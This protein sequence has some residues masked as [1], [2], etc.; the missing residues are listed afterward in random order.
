MILIS[1]VYFGFKTK[2]ISVI[3][4]YILQDQK[5]IHAFSM[6]QIG[7]STKT[8]LVMTFPKFVQF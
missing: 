5:K 3:Q 6:F 1:L 7:S 2:Q 8:D 4:C